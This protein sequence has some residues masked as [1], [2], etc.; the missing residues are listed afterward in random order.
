MDFTFDAISAE[1][2]DRQRASYEPLTDALREL[3]DVGIHTEV[4]DATVRQALTHLESASALLRRQQ[5]DGRPHLRHADT[6][7]VIDWANPAVGLR[8]AIAPPMRIEHEADGG[9]WSEFTLG[10]AYEGPPGWVHGGICALVLDHLLGE[11]ASEGLSKPKFTGTI[12]LRYLRGTPLGP[13]RAEGRIE[14]SEGVK[15]YARGF[16]MDGDGVTVEADGVFIEPAWARDA[17]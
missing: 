8:N 15:T 14:R 3:I 11:V 16:L 13:L 17:G 9:C 5:R 6:G 2:Y 12:S 7:R 10:P 4:D 1:D